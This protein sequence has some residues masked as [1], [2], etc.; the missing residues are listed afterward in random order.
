MRIEAYRWRLS[1]SFLAHLFKAT[2]KQH[3]RALRPIL[4]RLLPPD[5][6]PEPPV[7]RLR[8]QWPGLTCRA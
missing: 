3:H 1:G 7:E 4:G 5:R 6:I 2:L 8:C